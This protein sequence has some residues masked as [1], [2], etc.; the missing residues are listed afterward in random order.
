MIRPHKDYID[1]VMDSS[2]ADRVKKMDNL[3]NKALRCIEYCMNK[4]NRLDYSGLQKK[5]NIEDL[6]L[7]RNRNLMKIIHAKSSTLKSVDSAKHRIELC[8]NTKVKIKTVFTAKT[9]VFNSPLY[10]GARLWNS[11]P[12]DL[13]MDKDKYIFRKKMRTYT[14]KP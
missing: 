13:Q 2:S 10:R 1:F 9:Q 12:I 5:Y 3:Q 11:L 8:S 6:K 7:R 4:E 14:F